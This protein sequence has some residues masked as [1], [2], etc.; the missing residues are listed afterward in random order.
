MKKTN[1][2]KKNART[3]AGKPR[4]TRRPR[5]TAP[6]IQKAIYALGEDVTELEGDDA[7]YVAVSAEAFYALM[8]AYAES[9]R[10]AT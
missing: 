3:R 4:A 1:T 10:E 7:G 8:A 9:A 5:A 6:A 2:T